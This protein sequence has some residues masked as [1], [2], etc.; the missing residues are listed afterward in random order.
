[1]DLQWQRILPR[2]EGVNAVYGVGEQAAG[3]IGD[4][5]TR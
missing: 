2:V 3:Q 5:A 1:V 4:Q